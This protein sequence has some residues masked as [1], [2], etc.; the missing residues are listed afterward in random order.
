MLWFTPGDLQHAKLIEADNPV[1]GLHRTAASLVRKGL[2]QRRTLWSA[3]HYGITLD[4]KE[5]LGSLE[6]DRLLP[7]GC[8]ARHVRDCGHQEGCKVTS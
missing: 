6:S 5:L 3:V 2:V 8:P 4:G 7:C 1:Q